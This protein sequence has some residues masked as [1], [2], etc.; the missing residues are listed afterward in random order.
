[1]LREDADFHTFQML[2]AAV[3]QYREWGDTREGRN[4][5]IALARYSAAH[6]PTQRAALQTAEIAMKLDRGKVLHEEEG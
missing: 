1:V 2:E 6:A 3:R 4:I 5:L